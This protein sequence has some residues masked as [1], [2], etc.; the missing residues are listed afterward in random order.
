MK[1]I[2]P[3]LVF[4]LFKPTERCKSTNVR[5]AKQHLSLARYPGMTFHAAIS[6]Y[7]YTNP[8]VRPMTRR[9][10]QYLQCQSLSQAGRLGYETTRRRDRPGQ[11]IR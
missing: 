7:S 4:A 11:I 1:P 8:E 3:P 5:P 9:A 10:K 2:C 6:A